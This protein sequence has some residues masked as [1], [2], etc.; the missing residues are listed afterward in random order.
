MRNTVAIASADPSFDCRERSP[1]TRHLAFPHRPNGTREG[2]DLRCCRDD[3]DRDVHIGIAYA[4]PRDP[5]VN[6]QKK[7]FRVH[8]CAGDSSGHA[9]HGECAAFSGYV[10]SQHDTTLSPP[11]NSLSAETYQ[12]EFTLSA[13]EWHARA[14]N[15]S[16]PKLSNSP[17]LA[18]HP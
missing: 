15:R 2:S 9:D 11:V 5:P 4:L 8:A 10:I 13:A 3:Q 14:A 16:F 12:A 7:L 1:R 17:E 18:N 6:P